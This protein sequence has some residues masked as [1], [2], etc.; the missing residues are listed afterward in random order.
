MLAR[1]NNWMPGPSN[2]GKAFGVET[3]VPAMNAPASG[4]PI[5]NPTWM[6]STI[7][8]NVVP[9][10]SVAG[11]TRLRVASVD[12][13]NAPVVFGVESW[14]LSSIAAS[15]SIPFSN[16]KPAL[17][18]ALGFPILPLSIGS[19]GVSFRGKIGNLI[20]TWIGRGSG[21]VA[22]DVYGTNQFIA[23]TG[24]VGSAGG[25]G[26]WPWDGVTTPVVL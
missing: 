17:Q 20:D 3:Y 19:S 14:P 21:D 7:N 5:A 10:G 22:G 8:Q 25:G 18:G 23:A 26:V 2:A 4:L 12:V 24:Y 13:P 11:V 1:S 15:F 9:N 16:E 6:W